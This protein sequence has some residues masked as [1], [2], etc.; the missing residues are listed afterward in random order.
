MVDLFNDTAWSFETDR[1][2][3]EC[4]VPVKMAR[5]FMADIG[6][7]K[8]TSHADVQAA[9]TKVGKIKYGADFV[10]VENIL[11]LEGDRNFDYSAKK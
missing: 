5:E 9:M 6:A 11:E 7:L 10:R 3:K 1:P 8:G 4:V 2:K